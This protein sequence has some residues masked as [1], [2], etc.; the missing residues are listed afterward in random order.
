[1]GSMAMTAGSSPSPCG[2]AH[3]G[4]KQDPLWKRFPDF[5]KAMR[6]ELEYIQSGGGGLTTASGIGGC[7]YIQHSIYLPFLQVLFRIFDKRNALFIKAED[8]LWIPFPRPW[9]YIAFWACLIMSRFESP[10]RT[11]DRPEKWMILL[12]R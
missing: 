4:V 3:S 6:L 10:S 11:L 12:G 2:R 5:G 7:G 8:F 9:Q 1:M